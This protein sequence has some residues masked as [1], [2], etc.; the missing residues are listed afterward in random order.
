M[1]EDITVYRHV[2]RSELM[3]RKL[4]HSVNLDERTITEG[5]I[6]WSCLLSRFSRA[7]SSSEILPGPTLEDRYF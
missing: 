6:L 1:L 7:Y 3:Q 5:L 4:N 2:G